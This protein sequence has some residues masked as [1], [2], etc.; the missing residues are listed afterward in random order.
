VNILILA[1]QNA[2]KLREFRGLLADLVA[3][4]GVRLVSP[5]EQ[6]LALA[7]EETASTYAENASLKAMALAQ[8]SNLVALGDDSGLEVAALNGAPGLYSARYAGPGA[9]DADRRRK[10]LHELSQVPAPRPARFVCAIAVAQPDGTLRLFEGECQGEVALAESGSGGFGFD[11][12]FYM[13]E[14]AATMAALPAVVK[15]TISHRARAVQ[16]ALPY[17][18]R[19]FGKP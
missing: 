12:V 10:L 4:T 1:T 7:V 16:A 8:A 19:L 17:L 9:S 14:Y 5:A 3:R 11:P 18:M 2:G 13:P 15:N 6:G